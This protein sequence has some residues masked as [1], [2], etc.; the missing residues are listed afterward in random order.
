MDIR[1]DRLE[2]RID[3]LESRMGSIESRMNGLESRIDS[4]EV[5]S[6]ETLSIVRGLRKHNEMVDAKLDALTMNT[7]SAEAV[8]ELKE[9]QIILDKLKYSISISSMLRLLLWFISLY[10]AGFL[11]AYFFALFE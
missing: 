3:G 10:E 8:K 4:L 7:A 2:P 6:Q 5:Q 9:H 1:F 11:P